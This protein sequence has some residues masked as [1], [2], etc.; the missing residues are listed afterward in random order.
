MDLS[1]VINELPKVSSHV[2]V[3]VPPAQVIL[4]GFEADLGDALRASGLRGL[5]CP[6]R[7][8]MIPFTILG[9]RTPCG[10]IPGTVNEP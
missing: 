9:F 8:K 1:Y 5:F 4:V 6:G 3:K 7:G 10:S 2:M